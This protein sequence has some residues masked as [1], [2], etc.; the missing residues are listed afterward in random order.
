MLLIIL[1]DLS[2]LASYWYWMTQTFYHVNLGYRLA[3]FT[4]R[5]QLNG[6]LCH[7]KI[8]LLHLTLLLYNVQTLW[9]TCH[10]ILVQFLHILSMYV[11][12]TEILSHNKRNKLWIQKHVKAWDVLEHLQ[13]MNDSVIN[14]VRV[15]VDGCDFQI[16]FGW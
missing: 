10:L 5:Y 11:N 15:R 4:A 13:N 14:T 2:L 9:G 12:C 3:K 8:T 7:Q 1:L 16:F 6:H